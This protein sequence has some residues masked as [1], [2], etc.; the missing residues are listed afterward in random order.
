MHLYQ[1]FSVAVHDKV[2]SG[3][4]NMGI[5]KRISFAVACGV[6]TKVTLLFL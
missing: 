5:Q 4:I 2:I 3:A 6:V 1:S